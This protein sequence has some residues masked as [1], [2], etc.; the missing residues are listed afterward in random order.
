L[1][2]H[3]LPFGFIARTGRRHGEPSHTMFMLRS[4]TSAIA[5]RQQQ[6]SLRPEWTYAK[7]NFARRGKF[8]KSF[9]AKSLGFCKELFC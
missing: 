6:P 4:P 8:A 3:Q 7:E 5:V 2:R 1:A 9:F